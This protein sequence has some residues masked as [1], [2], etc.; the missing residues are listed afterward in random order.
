GRPRRE[1]GH[2]QP[3]PYDDP[4][5][6]PPPHG[7]TAPAHAD[8]PRRGPGPQRPPPLRQRE[9]IQDVLRNEL[10]RA[11][12]VEEEQDMGTRIRVGIIGL[13]PGIHW[14]AMAHIPALAALPDDYEVVGVA[15]TSLASAQRAAEAFGLPHAFANAQALVES[16]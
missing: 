10:S 15:N 16:P 11:L 9:K 4:R 8:P 14:A 12:P 13:N 5:P 7:S 1:A 6:Q 3:K 2:R